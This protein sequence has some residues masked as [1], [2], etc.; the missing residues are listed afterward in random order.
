VRRAFLAVLLGT[1]GAF[2]L[3]FVVGAV[4]SPDQTAPK[5]EQALQRS[6][7]ND[8]AATPPE[9]TL[10]PAW[11]TPVKNHFP[12]IPPG[13]NKKF[14]EEAQEYLTA[15]LTSGDELQDCYD[16]QA[17]F[18]QE[19]VN[20]Y[21][22][23]F[24]AQSNIATDM[25]QHISD[26]IRQ[27]FIQACAWRLVIM[28][29]GSEYLRDTDANTTIMICRETGKVSDAGI[30]ARAHAIKKTIAS[31]HAKLVPVPEIDFDPRR[32]KD[33]ENAGGD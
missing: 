32:D 13:P 26:G 22:G 9:V 4:L 1:V 25:S 30:I 28:A 8:G 29:S 11:H 14:M 2:A 31:H 24:L 10:P 23:D 5:T 12:V 7:A 21:A 16:D 27:N 6:Q 17:R 19:Y 18:E 20:A 3:I 15:C 33:E